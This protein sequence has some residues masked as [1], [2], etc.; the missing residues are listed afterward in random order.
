MYIEQ[1][2]SPVLQE[3]KLGNLLASCQAKPPGTKNF[4]IEYVNK[5][6]FILYHLDINS[7]KY[8]F[9]SANIH[10]RPLCSKYF[11]GDFK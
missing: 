5:F 4:Q 3:A 8:Q 10:W 2:S 1:I 6:N 9:N 11:I 7:K